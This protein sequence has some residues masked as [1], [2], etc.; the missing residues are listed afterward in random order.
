MSDGM[1]QFGSLWTDF[2]AIL[3]LNIFRKS[4]KKNQDSLKFDKNNGYFK[5]GS[6]RI[7]DNI[8]LSSP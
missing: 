1:E 5:R 8:S 4:V 2:H 3:Y 7:F 6:K